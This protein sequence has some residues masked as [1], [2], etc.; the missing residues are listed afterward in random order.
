MELV[1]LRDDSYELGQHCCLGKFVR[2]LMLLRL[3]KQ[4]LCFKWGLMAH[5][6]SGD[7]ELSVEANWKYGIPGFAFAGTE[8]SLKGCFAGTPRVCQWSSICEDRY[9]ALCFSRCSRALQGWQ[10]GENSC[11]EEDRSH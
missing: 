3:S 11:I 5:H 2:F 7:G 9:D 6:G 4:L 8:V 10:H 1:G